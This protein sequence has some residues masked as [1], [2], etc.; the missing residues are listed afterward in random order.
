MADGLLDP[1]RV[2]G[3]R[4]QQIHFASPGLDLDID[5]VQRATKAQQP[6]KNGTVK[7]GEDKIRLPETSSS[8]DLTRS[9]SRHYAAQNAGP[10]LTEGRGTA[11]N[12]RISQQRFTPEENELL[13]RLDVKTDDSIQRDQQ[14]QD[15]FLAVRLGM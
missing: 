14:D 11:A 10:Q 3:R 7:L 9:R 8:S 13:N 5:S 6:A 2:D 12:L 1:A 15:A 4:Q